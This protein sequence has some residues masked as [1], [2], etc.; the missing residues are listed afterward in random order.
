MEKER[1]KT[2]NKKTNEHHLQEPKSIHRN[3]SDSS[4]SSSVG[5]PI[6]F[7]TMDDSDIIQKKMK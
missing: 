2:L 6:I 4:E 7:D 3:K 1:V 5:V